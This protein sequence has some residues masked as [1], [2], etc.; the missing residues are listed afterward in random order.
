M[1]TYDGIKRII[2]KRRINL[3]SL[4]EG[5]QT[6]IS[7]LRLYYDPTHYHNA[8]RVFENQVQILAQNK[9]F[10]FFSIYNKQT[11]EEQIKK[12]KNFFNTIYSLCTSCTLANKEATESARRKTLNKPINQINVTVVSVFQFGSTLTINHKI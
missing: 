6:K 9:N 11:L 2:I 3:C 1:S 12:I 4:D 7:F 5:K 8:N 10:H